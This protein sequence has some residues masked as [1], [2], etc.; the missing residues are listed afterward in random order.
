MATSVGHAIAG[1]AISRFSKAS[2]SGIRL[3]II[4]LCVFVAAMPDLDIVPGLLL[5]KPVLYHQGISHSL[6]LAIP[7]SGIIAAVYKLNGK[8]FSVIFLLCFAAYSSHLALDFIGP[9]GR[10]PLGIPLFWPVSE[11]TF[12]SP[13][14]ILLGIS[15]ASSTGDSTSEWIQNLMSFRNVGVIIVEGLVV[16]PFIIWDRWRDKGMPFLRSGRVSK[17]QD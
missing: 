6:G 14:T 4:L 5:G 8:S 7:V 12:I 17:G 3:N 2:D 11:R 1:Y 10:P 15:H 13:V 16:A 9:D